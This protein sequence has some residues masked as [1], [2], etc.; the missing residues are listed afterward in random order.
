MASRRLERVRAVAVAGS[1]ALAALV[2]A[3]DRP[4]EVSRV[5]AAYAAM[6]GEAL[7]KLTGISVSYQIRQFDPGQVPSVA[8]LVTAEPA[9]S[10]MTMHHDTKTGMTR[11][12]WSRP[13]ANGPRTY[14]EIFSPEM[15]IV[16]G[17]DSNFGSPARATKSTPPQ[18][19]MSGKRLRVARRELQRP[20]FAIDMKHAPDK[21]SAVADVTVAG[22]TYPAMEF[23][24]DHG[25]MVVMYDPATGLPVRIRNREW[26]QSMGDADFDLVFA[27]W[28]EV[29]GVK[30]PYSQTYTLNDVPIAEVTVTDVKI[31][32]TLDPAMFTIPEALKSAGVKPAPAATAPYQ[33]TVRRQF[34]GYYL[35]SDAQYTDEGGKL[36][37]K[38]IAPGVSQ[39][40]GGTHNALIVEADDHLVVVDAPGDDAQ[41][42]IVMD[43]AAAKYPGKP[44]RY[45]VLTHH[46][47]DHSGGLRAYAAAGAT[48]ISGPGTAEFYRKMLTAPQTLNPAGPTAPITPKIVEVSGKWSSGGARAVEAYPIANP[49]AEGML[50]ANVPAARLVYVTDI[51]NPGFPLAPN[52]GLSAFVDGVEKAGLQPLLAAG[53]H[54]GSGPYAPM[55]AMARSAPAAAP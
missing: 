49:H 25:P 52:P 44:V 15:G 6:G 17:V 18:Y 53:G 40:V 10:T 14:V 3:C 36:E 8:N 19:V 38:E 47:V 39:A 21:V 41:S 24:S 51:A 12:E 27:D 26:D 16:E 43:L 9:V 30:I 35:D 31:N 33:W 28:R 34:S 50:I 37:L 45:V 2:G 22:D 54:G 55:A 46:H 23:R 13:G 42:K 1:F 4:A 48:V 32:P 29:D 7:D 20:W 5:D 11:Q